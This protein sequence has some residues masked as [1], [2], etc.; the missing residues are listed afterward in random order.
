MIIALLIVMLFNKNVA[1]YIS[2]DKKSWDFTVFM[3]DPLD[4]F[5]NV[6]TP[7]LPYHAMGRFQYPNSV[8]FHLRIFK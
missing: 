2:G 5:Y 4:H 1:F 6:S 3:I 8:I 7:L